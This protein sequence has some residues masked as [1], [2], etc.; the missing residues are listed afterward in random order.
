M[1]DSLSILL[2]IAAI[3]AIPVVA[4]ITV[5]VVWYR[6]IVQADHVEEMRR[7]LEKLRSEQP[8]VW[9]TD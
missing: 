8:A 2:A 6:L 5:A 7:I 9:P 1:S 3:G 4:V